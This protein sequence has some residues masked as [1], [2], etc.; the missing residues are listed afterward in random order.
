V[1]ALVECGAKDL[2][3]YV[4]EGRYGRQVAPA[5]RAFALLRGGRQ[6]SGVWEA[7]RALRQVPS[8]RHG[9]AVGFSAL[10]L[11]GV[12][13][14]SALDPRVSAA[15]AGPILEARGNP[16]TDAM[17]AAA[18]VLLRAVLLDP[19]DPIPLGLLAAARSDLGVAPARLC[20]CARLSVL[21]GD[22]I[23]RQ[24]SDLPRHNGE[25]K[26]RLHGP[27]A[28][29]WLFVADLRGRVC[30]AAALG[31]VGVRARWTPQTI[32]LDLGPRTVVFKAVGQF[33]R[34][35]GEFF[36]AHEAGL[37]DWIAGFSSE[38]VLLDVGANVGLFSVMAAALRG[39]RCIAV[40]PSSANVDLLV[41][42]V[43][44]NG[45]E[46]LISIRRV[47]LS[48]AERSGRL[49]LESREPGA[50]GHAFET[51]DPSGADHASEEVDGITADRLVAENGA[52]IPTRV[53][54]DV[55]GAE[56]AVLEG[57]AGVLA[58]HRLRDIRL[59]IRWWEA[60]GDWR[61]VEA[62][63]ARGFSVAM[64][65]DFKN[66]LFRRDPEGTR[67]LETLRSI[68]LRLHAR[69]SA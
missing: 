49:V 11:L 57:M 65:D 52:L 16:A 12:A 41:A 3:V 34:H 55:D 35:Y 29:F 50:A 7:L 33:T 47:A 1:V 17:A 18:A 39:A 23:A 2:A 31:C 56:G 59:E 61:L 42:N 45:L 5:A 64:A 40:E 21:L 48:D 4:V 32:A 68:R 20:D 62:L 44:A 24:P 38:D 37:W 27:A 22:T 54:I 10:T 36:F 30:A 69:R 63:C 51:G 9:R 25:T 46:G 15:Y 53:K 19:T 66:L 6:R 26:K 43:A 13:K 60:E 58:D 14:G 67:E 8:D 28:L